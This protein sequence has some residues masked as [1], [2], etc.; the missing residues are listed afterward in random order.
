MANQ[1]K[2]PKNRDCIHCGRTMTFE[3]PYDL[4]CQ[5]CREAEGRSILNGN[6]ST[7]SN[8]YHTTYKY[9]NYR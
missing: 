9:P 3:H 7:T 1:K 5:P 4:R 2:D 6:N 8:Q